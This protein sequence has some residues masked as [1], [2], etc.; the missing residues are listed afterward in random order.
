MR[1]T[2]APGAVCSKDG[3]KDSAI[4]D[5]SAPG[6]WMQANI[7]SEG[8]CLEAGGDGPYWLAGSGFEF[9]FAQQFEAGR[10]GPSCFFALHFEHQRGAGFGEWMFFDQRQDGGGVFE[11]E[12]ES[13][14][15]GYGNAVGVAR[16]DLAK[17]E[18]DGAES[19][20][21]EQV[22]GRFEGMARVRAPADPDQL[23][24]CDSG[25]GGGYGVERIAGID[26]GAN[27]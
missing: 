22:I 13:V 23:R 15:I 21:V 18:N 24:E 9:H 3:E 16:G 11:G 27:L 4:A 26:V 2:I 17:I 25:C 7:L 6:L 14:P 20:G 10:A 5:R 1:K 12:T 8:F 19:A